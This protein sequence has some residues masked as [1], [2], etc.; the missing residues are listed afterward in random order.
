MEPQRLFPAAKTPPAPGPPLPPGHPRH[1]ARC[2]KAPDA[3]SKQHA[4]TKRAQAPTTSPRRKPFHSKR[5]KDAADRMNKG[6]MKQMTIT[7]KLTRPM[8]SDERT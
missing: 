7:A 8:A 1:R 5:S 2:A 4:R 6:G 3:S